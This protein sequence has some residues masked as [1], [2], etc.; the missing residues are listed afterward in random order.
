[1]SGIVGFV[2]KTKNKE[3]TIEIILN[4]IIHR[5]PKELFFYHDKNIALAECSMNIHQGIHDNFILLLDGNIFNKDELAKVLKLKKPT[6]EEIIIKGFKKWQYELPKY[7]RGNFAFIL[8]DKKNKILYGARDHFGVKPLYYSHNK[9]FIFASEIKAILTYPKFKKEFNKD[10]LKP[11]LT[12]NF[13]PCDETFFKGIFTLN[14]GHY[15][16]Y[17][18]NKLTITKYYEYNFKEENLKKEEFINLISDSIEDSVDKNIKEQQNFGSFL[19]SGIDSSYLVSLAK[20]EKAFTVGYEEQKYNE[21]EYAK[22]LADKLNIKHITSVISKKDYLNIV[23]KIMDHFDEP[24]ADPAT[25]ALYFGMEKASE[26]VDTILSGEGADEFF[27]GYG[28]Y[29]D[30]LRFPL[31]SKIPFFI[32]RII[33]KIVSSLPEFK[34]SYFFI[35]RGL[36]I[37]EWYIGGNYTFT[38]KESKKYLNL[39]SN[40]SISSITNK[41]YDNLGGQNDLNKMQAFDISL[42]LPKNFLANNDKISSIFALDVRTPF[43][44]TLVFDI[45]S[46]LPFK[47]K[48]S[49]NTSKIALREA[50]EKVLPKEICN[51]KKLGF[52]VPLREW[53]RSDLF[54]N[55]IKDT[56]NTDIAAHLFNQK[57]IIKLLDDHR[58]YKKD[59]FKKVWLIYIF[60]I[61][62]EI[63]FIPN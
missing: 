34:G 38:E 12:F 35:R 39:D 30:L 20:P 36:K 51:R 21:I 41:I 42:F 44:D 23:P 60:L 55:K 57:K 61:W 63:H 62:Y 33:S 14:P 49:A 2:N 28:I 48:I 19:S 47:Y 9:N 11:F 27:A 7:L 37:E 45:A 52:P 8:W 32:R 40:I 53:I 24:I 18:N 58:E 56:F 6:D 22:D 54:Y 13:N 5:G 25:I 31:Y 3:K 29:Q 46:K 43:T 4:K 17:Q 15:F 26:E 16:I 50:T 1:M 10:V 59:T